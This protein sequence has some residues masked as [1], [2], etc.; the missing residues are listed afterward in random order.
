MNNSNYRSELA[1]PADRVNPFLS[2]LYEYAPLFFLAFSVLVLRGL[3]VVKQGYLGKTFLDKFIN[4]VLQSAVGAALAVGCAAVLPVVYPQITPGVM[5][6]ATVVMTIGGMKF[7]DAL[8]YKYFSIHIVDMA[9]MEG[10]AGEWAAMSAEDRVKCMAL[11]R[12]NNK[13]EPADE[14]QVH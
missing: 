3:R 10:P 11:W 12:E 7:I 1:M 9:D 5:L 2:L 6:G 14:R 4:I 8:A 13:K